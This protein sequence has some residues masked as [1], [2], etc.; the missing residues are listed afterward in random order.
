[1]RIVSGTGEDLVPRIADRWTIAAV[2]NGM[3]AALVKAKHKPPEWLRLL[4]EEQTAGQSGTETAVFGMASFRTGEAELGRIDGV[5]GTRAGYVDGQEVVEVRFDPK[6][7]GYGSLV[8]R[9]AAR[10]CASRV[11]TR[12]DAQQQIAAKKVGKRAVRTDAPVRPDKQPKYHL[13]RTPLQFL[14]MTELQA[15]RINARIGH[16]EF[17]GMLSPS[18]LD[19]L[20]RIR[21]H[22]KAGWKPAIGKP[23]LE[24]WASAEKTA[25][26][27]N[28]AAEKK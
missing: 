17:E 16:G 28:R 22:P 5:V 15:T 24:A 23:L 18:Q 1:V 21:A 14:P 3:M 11:L 13:S 27:V 20:R 7:I 4:A 26:S 19:L 10:E 25:E 8:E 9:A 6:V 2:A 12:S